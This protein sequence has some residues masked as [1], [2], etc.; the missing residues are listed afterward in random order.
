[1]SGVAAHLLTFNGRGTGLA[2][3]KPL[4][5]ERSRAVVADLAH[6]H[7]KSSYSNTDIARHSARVLRALYQRAAKF[8]MQMDPIEHTT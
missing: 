1:M 5:T 4:L 2:T 6:W 8:G 7:E 3:G